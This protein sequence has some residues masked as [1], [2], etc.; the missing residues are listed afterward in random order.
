MKQPP[1]SIRVYASGRQFVVVPLVPG[2]D[3]LSVEAAPAHPV[4]LTMGRP[5]AVT[6]TRAIRSAQEQSR[7]AARGD[8]APWDGDCGKW[9]AHHLLRV[10]VTWQPDQ[11]TIASGPRVKANAGAPAEDETQYSVLPVDTPAP[12]IAEWLIRHLGERLH[13]A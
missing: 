8:I 2:P 3:G 6:L 11:I 9:W 5:V 7:A 10:T 13:G 12:E 1:P 4:Y